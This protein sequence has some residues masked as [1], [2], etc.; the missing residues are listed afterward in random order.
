M[1]SLPS[2]VR[3]FLC[4]R[5]VDMRKSFDGLSGLVEECFRQD[6][7]TG[8]LFLFVN[9]RH[10]RRPSR[11]PQALRET[12]PLARGTGRGCGYG[13][14]V[15]LTWAQPRRDLTRAG[16]PSVLAR[17]ELPVAYSAGG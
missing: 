9:R 11:S 15:E 4:T 1:I 6:L 2:A 16:D 12:I 14:A 17:R 13:R 7:L 8:H 5:S 3:A 10:P